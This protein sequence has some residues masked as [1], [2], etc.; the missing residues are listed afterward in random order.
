MSPR[1]KHLMFQD[2]EGIK[3]AKQLLEAKTLPKSHLAYARRMYVAVENTPFLVGQHH[4]LM[5]DTIDKVFTGEIKRLI[6]C[7]PP[8]YSKSELA[9]INLVGRGFAINPKARFIHASFGEKLVNDNS[10]RIKNHTQVPFYQDRWKLEFKKDS[11]AKGLWRTTAGGHFLASPSGGVIT[12]FRAGYLNS[13]N[14]PDD[15]SDLEDYELANLGDNQ[16]FTGAMIIDDPLKPDDAKSDPI[17]TDINERWHGTFKSRLAH[18]DVPVII[19]MQRLHVDDFVGSV[20]DTSGQK[21]H[22]LALPVMIDGE[23]PD[24]HPN[25][26]MIPHGLP[27]GPLWEVKHTREKI[28][29]E[30]QV[31]NM[32]YQAQYQQQPIMSGGNLFK[33]EHFTTF[34]PERR[35]DLKRRAIF[36]DTASKTKERNDYSVFCCM[37]IDGDGKA[38]LLDLVFGKWEAPELIEVAKRFWDK[39]KAKPWNVHGQLEKM[40]V[41]D[42]SS[43]TML[44]QT[45][46]SEGNIP[47]EGIQVEVD[48]Y[49]RALGVIPTMA[50]NPVRLPE[51]ADWVSPFL[52]QCFS[53]PDGIH[54]DMVDAMIYAVSEMLVR[55]RSIYDDL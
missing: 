46:A 31:D 37:G 50:V 20:L 34:D 14:M 10:V 13:L 8:G 28:E 26:I 40:C 45:L 30:L 17:R 43:G 44:I 47:I 39:Q 24:Q 33:E 9:V 2:K 5:C 35:P 48:K 3:R 15:T 19:I 22:Y 41:E 29:T 55:S 38:Y 12:G 23:L 18:E 52:K 4:H 42:K 53:F 6:I 7:V 25:A 27:D 32:Q 11:S 16:V 21:W 51:G 49:T 1:G 54:D 36:A